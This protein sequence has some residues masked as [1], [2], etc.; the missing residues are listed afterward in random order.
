MKALA[1]MM[2][3]GIFRKK[4]QAAKDS[5][6]SRVRVATLAGILQRFLG[7]TIGLAQTPI[8]LGYLGNEGYGLMA[9]IT[10]VIGW[11]QLSNFGIAWGLQSSLTEAVAREDL[12]MQQRLVSTASIALGCI[13]GFVAVC[14]FAL[15]PFVNW[16]ALFPPT[17]ARFISEIS[18]CVALV[19]SS[20]LFSLTISFSNVVFAARQELHLVNLSGC[21]TPFFSLGAVVLA[22]HFRLG[23]IGIVA[24]T[25]ITPLLL[26]SVVSFYY[27]ANTKP[28]SLLPRFSKWDWNCWRRIRGSGGAFFIIQIC[29]VILFQ[30]DAFILAHLLSVET[31]TPYSV[32]QKLFALPTAMF[33]ILLAPMWSA[34]GNAQASGD[35]AWVRRNHNRVLMVL[36][37][38]YLLL[39]LTVALFGKTFFRLWVG[40]SAS[41]TLALL[42]MLLAYHAIRQWTDAHATLINGLDRMK[43]Q[44]V[45]AVIHTFVTL[46]LSLLF[47]RSMGIIGLPVAG[48]VGYA[49]VSGWFLPFYTR[50]ILRQME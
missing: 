36:G 44:T 4:G 2:F 45:S 31:V 22:V 33:S 42:L 28:K 17:T 26:W 34:Y 10:A 25:S 40:E 5:R 16:T 13:C 49:L 21:V 14:G 30:S 37:G 41:P 20:F 1:E 38:L 29:C 12:E 39:A 7:G 35:L 50:R 46:S 19:F 8:I 27:L 6:G 15:G 3:S 9:T 11:L 18:I 24:A 23:L 43:A 47:V 32:A 48:F